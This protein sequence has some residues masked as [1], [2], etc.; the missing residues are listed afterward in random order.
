VVLPLLLNTKTECVM[1][2]LQIKQEKILE[3][4]LFASGESL[5]LGR[6]AE[7]IG[8]DL[9][10]TR[11]LLQRM[12]EAYAQEQAGILLTEADDCYRLTTN[13]V[14][15]EYIQRLMQ[16]PPRKPFTQAVLE[17]LSVIAYKQ[18]V[19]KAVIEELRGVNVDWAVN[20]LVEHGLVTEKGR[21]DAP[22]KPILFGT[23][24]DFLRF[25]GLRSVDELLAGTE[26]AAEKSAE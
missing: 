23:T 7:A 9:P 11:N 12:G 17:T 14:Y 2:G 4:L 19:T 21:L 16:L 25:F 22:G 10:V 6:L 13:P 3:A 15:Y 24:E 18:P 26:G 5:P 8:C 1:P 20:R